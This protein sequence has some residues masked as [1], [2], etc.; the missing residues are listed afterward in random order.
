M[1]DNRPLT[2]SPDTIKALTIHQPWA[3]AIA[4][5][6][7]KIASRMRPTN[8]RGPMLIHA[9]VHRL[10]V[11]EREDICPELWGG[12]KN[13]GGPWDRYNVFKWIDNLPL[14][15]IIAICDLV[16]C[17]PVAKLALYSVPVSRL[18]LNRDE[19]RQERA[20]GDYSPGRY[21]WVLA[22]VRKLPEPIPWRGQQGLWNFPVDKLPE[23]IL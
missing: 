16:D 20:L 19:W 10:T 12:V 6:A 4:H 15:V 1:P 21:G 17:L 23:G 14:G 22:N 13:P 18:E 5:G 9:G 3:S 7:K 11:V 2:T 8:Y